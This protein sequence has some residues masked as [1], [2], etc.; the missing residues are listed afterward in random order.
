MMPAIEE[1]QSIIAEAARTELLPRFGAVARKKADGSLVTEADLAMQQRLA[2]AL[3][4]RWPQI[5][6]LG[7]EMPAAQQQQ[8]LDESREGLWLLD[9]LDGTTNFSMGLPFFSVS[10]ALLVDGEIERGVVYDPIRD[11][12]FS[13]VKGEGAA[14]DGAPLRDCA[15]DLPLAN[16]IGAVDFKRLSSELAC[17]VVSEPPFASQ[18]NCGSSALDWC[19]LAAGRYHV[20]LHGRQKLWDYAAGS[21]I[22]QEAGGRAATLEGEAVFTPRLAP[23]S[24]VAGADRELFERWFAWVGDTAG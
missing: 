22:L 24:V 18:R 16:G 14:L 13:A 23:R 11:E 8:L 6:L 4:K 1:L 20:Y 9:P 2:T 10:L 3:A 19:T 12:S 15:P 17:R 21:L 7:E 5:A